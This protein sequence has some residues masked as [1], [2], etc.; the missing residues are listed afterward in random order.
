MACTKSIWFEFCVLIGI[1]ER[2][3]TDMTVRV[4]FA[5][6]LK[7]LSIARHELKTKRDRR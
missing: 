5:H 2:G 4:H 7:V 6:Q 3:G 1:V